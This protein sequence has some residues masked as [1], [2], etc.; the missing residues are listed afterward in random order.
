MIAPTQVLG[1]LALLAAALLIPLGVIGLR[2]R[3]TQRGAA[4]A[5]LMFCSGRLDAGCRPRVAHPAHQSDLRRTLMLAGMAAGPVL[6][7]QFNLAYTEQ[8]RTG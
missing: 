1:L 4:F 5:A 6:W 7:L 3:A 8:R 2:E